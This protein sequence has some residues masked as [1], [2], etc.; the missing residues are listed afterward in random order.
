MQRIEAYKEELTASGRWIDRNDPVDQQTVEWMHD[1]GY[2][3]GQPHPRP[4]TEHPEQP[5]ESEPLASDEPSA[6]EL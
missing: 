3:V 5:E 2:E 6:P 1:L 4:Q